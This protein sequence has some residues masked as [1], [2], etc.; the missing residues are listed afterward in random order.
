MVQLSAKVEALIIA[1]LFLVFCLALGGSV[2]TT[3]QAVNHTGWVFTGHETVE[4]MIDLFPLIY[5]ASIVL[6][7]LGIV[8]YSITHTND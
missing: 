1:F 8:W 4:T 3:V 6:G 7:F 5:Y 2:V